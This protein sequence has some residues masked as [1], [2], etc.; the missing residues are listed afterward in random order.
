VLY[1]FVKLVG[2]LLFR[3]THLGICQVSQGKENVR[4]LFTLHQT[5]G[6]EGIA[7]SGAVLSC[8]LLEWSGA[9]ILV[10]P[11]PLLRRIS[12]HVF[13]C[14]DLRVLCV[15]KCVMGNEIAGLGALSLF[16]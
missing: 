6:G 12:M 9:L 13:S 10:I 11:L 5:C 15:E 2:I 3:D 7:E 8:C 16:S 1:I 4:L 14:I